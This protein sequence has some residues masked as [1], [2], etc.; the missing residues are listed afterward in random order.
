MLRAHVEQTSSGVSLRQPSARRVATE[1]PLERLLSDR[2]IDARLTDIS[3]NNRVFPTVSHVH[4]L[5]T[6]HRLVSSESTG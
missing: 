5:V 1:L 2:A 4:Y 3:N 6:Y